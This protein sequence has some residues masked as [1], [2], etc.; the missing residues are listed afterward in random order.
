[1]NT[2]K[3]GHRYKKHIVVRRMPYAKG[4]LQLY[5]Y[6]FP[7]TWSAACVA[8]RELIKQAQR[9]AHALEHAHTPEALEW[10]IRFFNHYF[11]VVKGGAKP[12]PGLKRYARFY[13]YTYVAIYRQLQAQQRQTTSNDL[14][15]SQTLEV[16]SFDSIDVEPKILQ[17]PADSIRRSFSR[18]FA[19]SPLR[20]AARRTFFSPSLDEHL[21]LKPLACFSG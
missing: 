11:T 13:Q 21:I 19:R 17:L 16:V 14:Q 10:R 1:M 3:E 6:H 15:Q 2:V 8:N 7:K 5:T 12:E 4:L 9:Q 20:S 18:S